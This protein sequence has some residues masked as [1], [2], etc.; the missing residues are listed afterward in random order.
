MWKFFIIPSIE[1]SVFNSVLE[2]FYHLG[3]SGLVR[4]NVQNSLDAKIPGDT[5]PVI[6]AI[7]T[8]KMEK[9]FIPGLDEIKNRIS[10][11]QGRNNYTKE[12]IAY[13]QGKMRQ[14]YINF[15]SFED[16]NT[17]GL[18]G[19]NNGQSDSN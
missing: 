5:R 11:L 8:G 1:E 17:K 13:M 14:G 10:C 7:R 9:E 3:I 19:A 18:K 2:K 6:I 16:S 12:T 4:E 15:I